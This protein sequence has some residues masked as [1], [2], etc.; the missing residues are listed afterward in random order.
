MFLFIAILWYLQV[1]IPNNA[2]KASEINAVIEAGN[3]ALKNN[4]SGHVIKIEPVQSYLKS[5][6]QMR[7]RVEQLEVDDSAPIFD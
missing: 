1:L 3:N 5:G 6:N 2:H 7:N 4:V